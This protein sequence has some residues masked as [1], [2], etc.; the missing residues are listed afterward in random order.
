VF[1]GTLGRGGMIRGRGV[2]PSFASVSSFLKDSDFG[3]NR[4]VLSIASA[5]SILGGLL[6]WPPGGSQGSKRVVND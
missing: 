6:P 2:L 5:P 1:G 3:V 4:T